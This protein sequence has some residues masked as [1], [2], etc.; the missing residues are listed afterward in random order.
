MRCMFHHR[1]QRLRL[2]HHHLAEDLPLA[3]LGRWLSARLN[4]SQAW[5]GEHAV[6]L[7]LLGCKSPG[8]PESAKP[9]SSSARSPL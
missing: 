6:A 4:P 7:D 3:R 1:L 2:R 8:S 9:A 5:D